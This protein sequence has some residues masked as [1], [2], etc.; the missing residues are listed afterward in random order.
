MFEPIH[1]VLEML[2]V[3]IRNDER[4]TRLIAISTRTVYHAQYTAYCYR[5]HPAGLT[6][7]QH[8]AMTPAVALFPSPRSFPKLR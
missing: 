1:G 4:V 2:R 3:I 6:I 7:L 8:T 5:T